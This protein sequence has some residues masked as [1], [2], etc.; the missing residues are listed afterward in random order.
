MLLGFMSRC[1]VPTCGS[2]AGSF[3]S[4]QQDLATRSHA[5]S[6]KVTSGGA[7]WI[8]AG[9]SNEDQDVVGLHIEVQ[10]PHLQERWSFS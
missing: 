5:P 2:E 8:S 4:G 10:R 1:S 6:C 3:V 9:A 7:S